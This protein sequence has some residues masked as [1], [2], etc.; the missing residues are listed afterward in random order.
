MSKH[1]VLTDSEKDKALCSLVAYLCRY[2]EECPCVVFF[3]EPDCPLPPRSCR[4]CTPELWSS[5]IY[6]K[7]EE[8][9]K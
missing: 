9:K 4:T 3:G 6:T 2:T 1:I 5:F 8:G 7:K